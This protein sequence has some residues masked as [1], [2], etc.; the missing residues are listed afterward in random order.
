MNSTINVIRKEIVAIF[1][2]TFIGIAINVA[3]LPINMNVFT[4]IAAI[5]TVAMISV[6]VKSLKHIAEIVN[7]LED[8]I[9]EL[10][11][12][13]EIKELKEQEARKGTDE[14]LF[15]QE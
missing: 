3:F 7:D 1:L 15:N 2:A 9:F 4:Y 12:T 8:T 13:I 10:E 11:R 5:G 6:V 14:D